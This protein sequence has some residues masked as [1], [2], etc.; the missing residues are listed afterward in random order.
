MSEPL[1]DCIDRALEKRRLVM[2]NRALKAE[3]KKRS[4][5]GVRILG[6]TKQMQQ[7]MQLLDAVIDTPADVL[8][9]GETGTGKELVA[10]YLHDHSQRS[11]H[12]FVAINCGAIPEELI[13]SELFGAKSGAFTGAKESREGKFTFAQGGTVFLDEIEAMSAALQVKLLRVLEER[14]VT[15]VGSNTDVPLD[16][17]VVAA[18]KVDLNTLVEQGQF[19]SDLF[20][21]LN[22]LKVQIPPLRARKADIPLLYKHF[23][24]IAATRFH[25][26]MQPISAALE[27]KLMSF[28]WPGNV[29]ELR[30]H[31]ERHILLADTLDQD[32]DELNTQSLSLAE[33]VSYYE[34][35]LIEEALAQ[36]QGS[37]KQAMQLLKLPRKTLYDK[38]NK[39]GLSRTMFVAE[40]E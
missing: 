12:N 15:P 3:V 25:K 8:I 22:L 13:E 40:E 26:P 17:R 6:E 2:E 20:Y 39:Y 33:K 16:I 4:A 38:M 31:A 29:R 21:R 1:L 5:P 28:D 19:R 10:R 35:S 32:L 18:T 9:Q 27:A 37:I 30:N 7:M 14:S 24:S 23:S 34:Q 36:S 11:N